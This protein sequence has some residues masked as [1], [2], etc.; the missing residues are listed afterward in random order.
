MHRGR[1]R[2]RASHSK[3]R[4][5]SAPG[6][7]DLSRSDALLDEK[8]QVGRHKKV[9]VSRDCAMK[10]LAVLLVAARR[11]IAPRMSDFA[12]RNHVLN[13]PIQ[14]NGWHV[15]ATEILEH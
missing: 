9:D 12:H 15:A 1:L 11:R 7:Y 4:R 13:Q 14:P 8:I 10:V 6:P 3:S 2:N 5:Q